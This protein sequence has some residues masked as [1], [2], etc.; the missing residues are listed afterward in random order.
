MAK[1]LAKRLVRVAS[2]VV[3]K[4][5]T[6]AIP[7]RSIHYSPSTPLYSRKGKMF[8]RIDHQYLA[9]VLAAAGFCPT[10]S[11]W[12]TALY[13][14]I[15][16]IVRA[17]GF[18]SEPFCIEQSVRQRCFLSSPLYVLVLEP[19]LRRLEAMRETLQDLECRIIRFYVCRQN[20]HHCILGRLPTGSK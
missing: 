6:Y 2:K 14:N 1:A 12:I 18:F 5:Q 20:D 10:F 4:A 17:N 3:G 9:A 13:N 19:L 8:D 7:G 11:G 15:E 16:S